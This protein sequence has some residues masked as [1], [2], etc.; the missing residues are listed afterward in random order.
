MTDQEAFKALCDGKCVYHMDL[1]NH[2][3]RYIQ[4][5]DG[6]IRGENGKEYWYT[7]PLTYA[8]YGWYSVVFSKFELF[9]KY[10]KEV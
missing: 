4:M 8:H 6:K 1:G 3:G 5:V 2:F 9:M 7:Q 10:L